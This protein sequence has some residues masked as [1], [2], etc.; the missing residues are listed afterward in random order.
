MVNALGGISA[1]AISHPHYYTS[2]VEW[3]RAFSDA[4]IHLNA[5]D[6]QWVMRP[7]K[8]IAFWGGETLPIGENLTLIHCGGH[9][10]GGTVL[11]W[12]GGAGGYQGLRLKLQA[13][14]ASARIL[15]QIDIGFGDAVNPGPDEVIYPTLLD[16][17]AP[18][19][20]CVFHAVRNAIRHHLLIRRGLKRKIA[21]S[22]WNDGQAHD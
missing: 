10:A 18:M 1:I 4:P 16:M 14:L 11:P 15:I 5:A 17:P 7:D 6:R 21:G 12:Q 19:T 3:S 22:D 9:F 13:T 8:A 20:L 2:M